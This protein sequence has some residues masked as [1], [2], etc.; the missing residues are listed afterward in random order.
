MRILITGAGGQV[1]RRVAGSLA[2]AGH[3]LVCFDAVQVSSDVPGA[4]I[5]GNLTRAAEVTDAMAGAEAVIHLGAISDPIAWEE[6]PTIIETNVLGTFNVL[7]AARQLC[8]PRV[9]LASTIN[10][11]GL[12]SWSKPWTPDYL[13]LDEQHPCRPDDNYGATKLMGEIMARG[14][15]VRHGLEIAC[16]R[17]TG[18]L[19]P[20]SPASILRY[21]N[22]LAN[23]DGELVNRM[24]SYLRSEDAVE[25]V[26]RALVAP[27]LGFEPILLAAP[28]SAVGSSSLGS[29]LDRHFP[30]RRG[31]LAQIESRHGP[32]ASLVSTKRCEQILGWRPARSYLDVASLGLAPAA[33]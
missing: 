6:Y 26:C 17:F 10:T 31:D 20:D 5:V 16:L 22:W 12:V 7:E 2:A 9:V 14:F 11:I 24:W 19:F 30:E 15:H 28:D 29:L 21:Q 13:P 4:K 8:I 25:G 18:V 32:N 27:S 1:G 33:T 3:E 23:P